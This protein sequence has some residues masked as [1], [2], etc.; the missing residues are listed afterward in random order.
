[1]VEARWERQKM[2]MTAV[3]QPRRAEW[4]GPPLPEVVGQYL[5]EVGEVLARWRLRQEVIDEA[6]LVIAELLTNVVQHA[7][8]TFRLVME[9]HAQLLH[10]AVDDEARGPRS[11]G[12]LHKEAGHLSGLRLVNR[13]ALRWGWK[14]RN[15][16]K[17]VWAEFAI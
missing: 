9:L 10:I 6:L 4:A 3:G 7:R 17:T 5:R 8:T 2:A 12:S 13:V 16:G 1:L 11:S 15:S 14:E